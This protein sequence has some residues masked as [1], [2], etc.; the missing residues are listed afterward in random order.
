M[1]LAGSGEDGENS[2]AASEELIETAMGVPPAVEEQA[3]ANMRALEDAVKHAPDLAAAEARLEAAWRSALTTRGKPAETPMPAELHVLTTP[4]MRFFLSYDPRP[5]LARVHC[6]VL[7]VDGSKDLQVPAAEN[8]AGI[9]AALRNNPDVST[10]ELPG[11][12]HLLQTAKTGLPLT[13][14]RRS[15]RPSRRWR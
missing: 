15:R 2:H 13:N 3:N 7:A 11:L 12:N 10:V 4:W 8:L 9:K 14:T 1:L 5:T 6:P